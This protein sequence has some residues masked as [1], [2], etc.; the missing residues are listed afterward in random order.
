M[1]AEPD[2]FAR[3]VA[4]F[5]NYKLNIVFSF[6]ESVWL[7]FHFT[8]LTLA[9][10]IYPNLLVTPRVLT[11][12]FAC[13]SVALFYLLS[14]EVFGRKERTAAVISTLLLALFPFH[15]FIATVPL[16]EPTFLFF[17]LLSLYLLFREKKN[18]GLFLLFFNMVHLIRYES[19]FLLPLLTVV[20]LYD[21]TISRT[22]RLIYIA[23]MSG[24]AV[25]WTLINYFRT[26][27]PGAFLLEKAQ[28]AQRAM[29]QTFPTFLESMGIWWKSMLLLIPPA[30]L[31]FSLIGVAGELRKK[32]EDPRVIFL[33]FVPYWLLI[34][35]ILQVSFGT[36]EWYPPRYV[37]VSVVFLLLFVGKGIVRFS[38]AFAAN[39]PLPK[40]ATYHATLGIIF[41]CT[42]LINFYGSQN[43][44]EKVFFF[45]MHEA[46]T[47]IQG[48]VERQEIPDN[49]RIAYFSNAEGKKRY[50]DAEMRY[51][52][53]DRVTLNYKADLPAYV[54][55]SL[56]LIV[57]EKDRYQPPDE[58]FEFL[59]PE[60]NYEVLLNSSDLV[61]LRAIY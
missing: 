2:A 6:A 32:K 17:L 30:L 44:R 26:H 54:P 36:M 31:I 49:F 4:A 33:I 3:P 8:L 35:L 18:Y 43:Y 22:R 39:F 23:L 14:L 10:Y 25:G 59:N 41:L 11:A 21:Q 16:S 60:F 58:E 57:I 13:G 46:S 53:H 37:Y 28:F 34:T 38:E 1:I 61:Y 56:D 20:I 47:Y 19:W 55:D 42:L 24:S 27:V 50:F 45:R 40:R 51:M 15:L 29:F 48:L 7:P 5:E 9:F 52:F 12:F